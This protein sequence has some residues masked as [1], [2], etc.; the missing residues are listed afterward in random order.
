MRKDLSVVLASTS[1]RRISLLKEIGVSFQTVSPSTDETPKKG[2]G[3]AALVKRLARDKAESVLA[4]SRVR[5]TKGSCLVI[6]ADTI[7]VAPDRKS[8]LGKPKNPKDALRM[9]KLL[10]GQSHSVF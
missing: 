6:S 1:P 5:K 7:V 8:I 9:I 3:P 10:S 2:E 4:H